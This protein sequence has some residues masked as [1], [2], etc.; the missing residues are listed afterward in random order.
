MLSF[1]RRWWSSQDDVTRELPGYLWQAVT[2]FGRS[3]TRQA[4]ALA[5]YAIFSVFPLSLLLAVVIG[6]LLG[7][8]VAQQQLSSALSLFL[9]EDTT[10]LLQTNIE[11]ALQQSGSFTLIALAGLIWSALG[12]FTNITFSLDVIFAVPA[13]R[14][15]WRQR[16][17]ALLMT[18]ILVA[19]ITGSFVTSAVLRL[20]S[21]SLLGQPSTWLNVGTIFLPMGL[22]MVIFALLFRY[23]P[24]RHVHWDAVW[25]AAIFG[26][27]GW[28]LAKAGFVLYT[29]RVVNFQFVYGSIATAIV[30]LLWAYLIAAIFLFSAELCAQLND[31]FRLQH[32]REVALLY[33]DEPDDVE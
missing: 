4:A 29:S 6:R 8:V 3:G 33:L 18:V 27:V 24:A 23:V 31:W 15:L 16:L 11:E 14:S 22:N 1:F 13:R 5:Y 10:R 26:A 28:E 20:I 21:A 2:N 7:P 25:P 9:P 19:L 17:V 12:L 32:E 30:L